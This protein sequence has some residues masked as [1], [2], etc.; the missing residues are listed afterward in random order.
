ML[1]CSLFNTFHISK[2]NLSF[3]SLQKLNIVGKSKYNRENKQGFPRAI[4]SMST[5]LYFPLLLTPMR[6]IFQDEYSIHHHL[7]PSCL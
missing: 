2:A 4:T 3:V 5:L 7:L 6:H 1:Q